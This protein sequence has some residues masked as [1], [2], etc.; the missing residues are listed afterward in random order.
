MGELG[1]GRSPGFLRP[2]KG[3]EPLPCF[4]LRGPREDVQGHWP[5]NCFVAGKVLVLPEVSL[6]LTYFL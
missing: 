1:G 6:P 3:W 2:T 4:P 5:Q